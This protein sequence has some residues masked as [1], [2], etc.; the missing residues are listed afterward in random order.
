MKPLQLRQEHH[1]QAEEVEQKVSLRVL[2]VHLGN[3]EQEDRH[4]E[5]ELLGA[6]PEV[7]ALAGPQQLLPVR[8]SLYRAGLVEQPW[9]ALDA[10]QEV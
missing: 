2:A 3:D 1:D 4:E 6:S 7:V 5:Q 9:R 8:F 10:M